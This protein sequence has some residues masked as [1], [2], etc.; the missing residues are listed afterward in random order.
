M[1]SRSEDVILIACSALEPTAEQRDRLISECRRGPVD[2]DLVYR[3]AVVHKIAPLIYENLK[4]CEPLIGSLPEQIEADFKQLSRRNSVRNRIVAD[5]IADVA[6]YFDRHS[7]DILL[8]KHTAYHLKL[9]SLYDMTMS[10]DFDLV[11]RP[12]AEAAEIDGKPYLW[13]AHNISDATW[14]IIVELTESY[15]PRLRLLHLEV[16]NRLHHDVV[17]NGVIPIDFRR[18]WTDADVHQV[19]GKSVYVPD[20]HDLIVISAVNIFRKPFLR[21]RNILEIHE[22]IRA[23]KKLDWDALS[24][25]VRSYQC[26]HLVYSALDAT[27]TI[28]GTDIRD[29]D[30]KALKPMPF[31][32]LGLAFVNSQISPTAICQKASLSDRSRRSRRGMSDLARRFFALDLRQ[33]IRFFWLRIILR[34]VAGTIRN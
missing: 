2:W 10:D 34:R 25:K 8:L 12:R 18:I 30:L 11:V 13:S 3:A 22:L 31:R 27:R 14:K 32:T 20:I 21:L 28:L 6:S 1:T 15:D 26:G 17:W 19:K 4:R 24:A 33:L 9:K 23:E 7:H 29:A 5:G 16:D